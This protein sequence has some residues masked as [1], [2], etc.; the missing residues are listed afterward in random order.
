MR[1]LLMNCALGTAW[2]LAG[3]LD[4]SGAQTPGR[5]VVM[6]ATGP[7]AF[8]PGPATTQAPV[9]QATM[10][11]LPA[12]RPGLSRPTVG[13]TVEPPFAAPKLGD[14]VPVSYVP[15]DQPAAANSPV[16]TITLSETVVITEIK[17]DTAKVAP[18]SA[19]AQAALP[20]S[21]ALPPSAM[22][23]AFPRAEPAPKRK[24][25][26]DL[27]AAACFAHA[28][29]YNW[30]FGQVEYSSVAKEWRLR[31]ASVDE[32][33]RFGGRVSLIEN[34]HVGL[35]R[36]GMCVHVRGHLVN[37][38]NTG[39]GPTFYRVEWYRTIDN[40]NTEQPINEQPTIA[41]R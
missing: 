40:P 14:I 1:R 9:V 39:N 31:Y 15:A 25:F 38:E 2:L 13:Q 37:P 7:A 11:T 12:A 29:D 23:A 34:H 24:S 21:A 19:D 33:D 8:I 10:I 27:S 30:I 18:S 41:A 16:S 36:D 35:L 32:T 20:A 28:P 6:P 26:V 22:P 17:H 4:S 3:K 5:P